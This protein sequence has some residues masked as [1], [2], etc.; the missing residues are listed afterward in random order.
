MP[1]LHVDNAAGAAGA[2]SGLSEA[3]FPVLNQEEM[4]RRMAEDLQRQFD[5]DAAHAPAPRAAAPAARGGAAVEDLQ[6]HLMGLMQFKP[7]PG[8][9]YDGADYDDEHDERG[10]GGRRGRGRGRGRK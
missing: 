6:A 3:A 1:T 9:E 5:S 8:Q 10:R 4:D 2:S 7:P